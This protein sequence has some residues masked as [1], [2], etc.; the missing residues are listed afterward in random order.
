M[1]IIGQEDDVHLPFEQEDPLLQTLPQEHVHISES[2]WPCVDL[3]QFINT[4]HNDPAFHVC[5]LF[6]FCLE[7]GFLT[8]FIELSSLT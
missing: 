2:K 4:Q 5:I 7:T 1:Q 6:L 8:P 3:C